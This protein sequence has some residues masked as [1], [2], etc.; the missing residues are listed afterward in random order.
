VSR[1]AIPVA[2]VAAALAL[3]IASVCCWLAGVET[4]HFGPVN[5]NAPSYESTSYSGPW[6]IAASVAFTVA[7]VLAIDVYRRLRGPVESPPGVPAGG[8]VEG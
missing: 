7:A 4:T 2:E 1:R 6:I 5:E 3:V 8:I